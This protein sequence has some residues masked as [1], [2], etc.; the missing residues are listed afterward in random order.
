MESNQ[1]SG[2]HNVAS[3]LGVNYD[4]RAFLSHCTTF[5]LYANS[6]QRML[7]QIGSVR[8]PAIEAR[9]LQNAQ[10]WSLPA[11]LRRCCFRYNALQQLS[12]KSSD[13]SAWLV[14]R[15]GGGQEK[16]RFATAKQTPGQGRMYRFAAH[17]CSQ[18]AVYLP[19]TPEH[20]FWT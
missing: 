14:A 10:S 9:T 16:C 19:H 3:R 15:A 20:C 7:Q 5:P 2:T 18:F 1:A 12:G 8:V 13:T 6:L 17:I 11:A 4:N